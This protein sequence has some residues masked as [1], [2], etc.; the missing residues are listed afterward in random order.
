MIDAI[1]GH[2][3]CN[4]LSVI[5]CEQLHGLNFLFF[6]WQPGKKQHAPCK[7]PSSFLHDSLIPLH[8]QVS[9][10][11]TMTCRSRRFHQ[12]R[13]SHDRAINMS[14]LHWCFLACVCNM[15]QHGHLER[16]NL[17]VWAAD[18]YHSFYLVEIWWG[19]RVSRTDHRRYKLLHAYTIIHQWCVA[20]PFFELKTSRAT[21]G[22]HHK[23]QTPKKETRF[24][25]FPFIIP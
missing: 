15:D 1:Q 17:L 13:H 9:H 20:C 10:Q 24:M 22:C 16:R 4:T 25:S 11:H 5:F 7:H 19:Q 18:T 3:F 8:C 23:M 14:K 12:S 6:L 2:V 21:S